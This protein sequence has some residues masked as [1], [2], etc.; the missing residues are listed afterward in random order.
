MTIVINSECGRMQI[1]ARS[2]KAAKAVYAAKESFD[3]EG[4]KSGKYPGSFFRIWKDGQLVES[5][6]ECE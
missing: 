4:A 1:K 6:G 2:I 5:V 3:F